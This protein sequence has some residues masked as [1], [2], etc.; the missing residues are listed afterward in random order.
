MRDM[1][2]GQHSLEVESLAVDINARR[3]L[4]GV[5]LSL[6]LGEIGC[7]LGSSGSGKTT[8][9]RTI[10][11]FEPVQTGRIRINQ[12]LVSSTERLLPVESRRVGMVFQDYVLFPHLNT[13][14][15]I[16][17]GLH[18]HPARYRRQRLDELLHL[19]E[20]GAQAQNYPHQLSGGEQQRVAIARAIAPRPDILLM[21]EPFSNLDPELRE[22]L[23][24]QLRRALQLEAVTTLIVSHNQIESFAMADY[25]GVLHDGRLLQWD[26]AFNLY[27][28]PNCPEVADFIGEGTF[29][30][31]KVLD[32]DTVATRLGKIH[33]RVGT[34]YAP[35]SE[36][37]V[38]IR[39]DDILHDDDSPLQATVLNKA[40]RGAAFLYTLG[41]G[42]QEH[43]LSLVPSHHDHPLGQPIGI[44]LEIDHLV[45]FPATVR[46]ASPAE[47]RPAAR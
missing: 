36:V 46:Q 7:L 47:S 24:W 23:A 5:S 8:L 44:R 41:L 19:L 18:G 31:G 43:I 14:D 22:Q 15:N 45:I 4:D 13:A 17:F 37:L 9:L 32:A 25:V 6:R 3:I 10:A 33:G 2:N 30:S 39:P 11:G 21:D 26:T 27:H 35:G 38:L 29:L 12:A 34:E 1:H 28:Q 20:L 16:C 42:E 40:F